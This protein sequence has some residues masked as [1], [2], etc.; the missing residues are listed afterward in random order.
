MRLNYPLIFEIVVHFSGSS[1]TAIAV[2]C[3]EGKGI[4]DPKINRPNGLT[5]ARVGG[6]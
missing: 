6:G 1:L 3:K 5:A 2:L 4:A